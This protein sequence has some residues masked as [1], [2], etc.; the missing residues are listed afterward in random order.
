MQHSGSESGSDDMSDGSWVHP[1]TFITG[2]APPSTYASDDSDEEIR[3]EVIDLVHDCMSSDDNSHE[4]HN[5][6]PMHLDS[7]QLIDRRDFNDLPHLIVVCNR[8]NCSHTCL[9]QKAKQWFIYGY[10]F[11]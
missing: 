10:E 8:Y 5:Q 1:Y 7:D 11:G 4:V 6:S 9:S 3:W 2:S